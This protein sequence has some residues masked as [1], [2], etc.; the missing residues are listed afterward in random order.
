MRRGRGEGGQS[1][2]ELA[3]ALPVLAVLA[4]LL[5]QVA[6]VVRDQ[7][8]LAHAA[9][10]A[11][12][13]AAVEPE[14]EAARRAALAGARLDSD[15]LQV[16]LTVPAATTAV[17]TVVLTYRSPTR[18]PVVGALVGDVRLSATAA[19]RGES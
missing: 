9:R 13:A 12:R 4:L 8:L 2:V 16:A 15:A 18:V 11:A 19:M 14:E 10:E 17:R 1:T 6:L 3:L 7:V 5:L